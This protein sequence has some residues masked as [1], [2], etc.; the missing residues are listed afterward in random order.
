[1]TIAKILVPIRGDG[2]GEN[3]LAH[4]AAVGRPHRAH[5]VALHTRPSP[6][7]L[8]PTG[9]A[10]PTALRKQL[11]EAASGMSDF[12]EEDL[13]GHL[14]AALKRFDI[15]QCAEPA[16]SRE[17]LTLSWQEAT[18]RQADAIMQHGRLADLIAV[19]KPERDTQL[20]AN[21]L[22]AALQNTGRP[23]LMCPP[24]DADRPSVGRHAMVAWAGTMENARA[25]ALTLPLIEA[26]EKV[27]VL[28]VG[29]LEQ[30][31][32]AEELVAYFSVRGVAAEMHKVP[33]SGQ[34]GRTILDEAG[35]L[36]A[37]LIVMGAYSHGHTR[38]IV[39]GGATQHV[40]DHATIP[41]AMVH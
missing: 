27:T 33:H 41:V 18:G 4:A 21:T 30:A 37:D 24:S 38:E 1:M 8:V 15:E 13:L 26:A 16:C 2:Y 35:A 23:V 36:G 6:E 25:V 32:N 29:E 34:I 10:L 22:Q 28:T 9:F 19:P 11:L 7:D 31:A 17:R 3:V 39:F 14:E 12:E 20:G 5:I 40:I